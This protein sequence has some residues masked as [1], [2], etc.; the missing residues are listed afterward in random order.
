M[1]FSLTLP[2][3]V[4]ATS[5]LPSQIDYV[6]DLAN[7]SRVIGIWRLNEDYATLSG[8]EVTSFANLKTGGLALTST[9]FRGVLATDNVIGRKVLACT[10]ADPVQYSIATDLSVNPG[11]SVG[12]GV[13][14]LD[15]LS[16]LFLADGADN[17]YVQSTASG[18]GAPQVRAYLGSDVALINTT[19]D[20]R[21]LMKIMVTYDA[22]DDILLA[23]SGETSVADTTTATVQTTT[24]VFLGSQI[25]VVAPEANIDMFAL[26]AVDINLAAN[27][28]LLAIYNQF[29][30]EIYR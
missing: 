20:H 18:F 5:N 1:T 2:G 29:L 25:G 10:K 9:S 4:A 17:L 19:G 26:F 27:A 30:S 12:F 22:S 15:D 28:D 6:A 3:T 24:N 13:R 23:I 11:I 7:D 16:R 14:I 8:S 21:R